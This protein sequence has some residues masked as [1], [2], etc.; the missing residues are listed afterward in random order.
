M[1]ILP[2]LFVAIMLVC[3]CSVSSAHTAGRRVARVA[4]K[5]RTS[6]CDRFASTVGSDA[7]GRGTFRQPFLT[8]TRLDR[9]LRPGQTG[10]LMGGTYGGLTAWHQIDTDGTSDDRITI[11]EAPGQIATVSGW[12][13][14]EASYTTV[15]DLRIDGSNTLYPTRAGT[16]CRSNVSQSLTISG[17]N[18]TLQYVEYFQ[19]IPDL[20]GNGIGIGYWG[21][22]DNTIIRH[23][24][25]HDV[26]GCDFYDHLIYLAGGRGAQIYDNWLWNDPHGWGIKLDPGPTGARIWGN[27]ID[28]AGS[29][30]NFG[31]SSGHRPTADN[32]V[33]DNIVMNSVGVSNP[34]IPW[35]YPGVLVTSPGMLSS[36]TG[37][38]LYDNDSFNNAGG[39][40]D[41]ARN[42][43][44]A[45]LD[46]SGNTKVAPRFVNAADHDF[47]LLSA[48][49]SRAGRRR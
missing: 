31:N 7:R 35:S 24:K 40:R 41:I 10:C 46:V 45:Q 20:R 11:R 8:L 15:E 13:D 27:V 4:Q 39:I 14:I 2:P 48:T 44:S 21:D 36:S 29:G 19:L 42:V 22:A 28:R 34:D 16:T 9:S 17:H 12:V 30:F 18:D 43:T 25:I 3:V 38:E 6:V 1:R 26:G 47:A 49:A 32:R 5:A 23:D 33:F 37:N